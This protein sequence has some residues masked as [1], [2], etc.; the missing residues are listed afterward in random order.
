MTRLQVILLAFC[1]VLF[2]T[3][4]VALLVSIVDSMRMS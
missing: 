3:T 2:I 1:G 4:L